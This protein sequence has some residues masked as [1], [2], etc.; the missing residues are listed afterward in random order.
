VANEQDAMFVDQ[1]AKSNLAEITEGKLAIQRSPELAVNE[2]GRWMVTDHNAQNAML[3]KEASEAGLPVPK[4]LSPEQQA[5]VDKLSKLS[6]TDFDRAY[7]SAQVSDHKAA[8]AL[9]Q[10]EVSR[11]EDPELIKLA[12][13]AI[14]IVQAH[15]KEAKI[16]VAA[17]PND[18]KAIQD[19]MA[20]VDKKTLL[21]DMTS[22]AQARKGGSADSG[23]TIPDHTLSRSGFESFA[24]SLQSHGAVNMGM[25]NHSG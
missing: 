4:D 19:L 8:L 23:G 9:L 24:D 6:G 25:L 14:P 21:A 16:L 17:E 20:G 10:Q 18:G 12:K 1:A 2:F 13:S 11:G 22:C 5:E 7:L 3:T 15:L